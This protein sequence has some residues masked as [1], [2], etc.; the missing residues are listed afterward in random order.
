[1]SPSKLSPGRNA[2]AAEA[3][4]IIWPDKVDLLGVEVSRV[5]YREAV[6]VIVRAAESGESGIVGCHAVHAIVTMAGDEELREMANRY[7]MITPDGQPVRWAMNLL[8]RTGLKDRVYGPELMLRL[9][10]QCERKQIPIYLYGGNE[11]VSAKLVDSLQKQF[12]GLPI[13]GA[14]APPFRPLTEQE[15]REVVNRIRHSGAKLVFVGLGCPK[16]DLFAH[17]HRLSISAVQV[18]VGAAF[19][20]HA[21]FKPMA[22]DWM[23][24][25]GLE[26][27]YRFCQEPRRLWK[28]YLVTN[29]LFIWKV[30]IAWLNGKV[31]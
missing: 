22:P 28:R 8:H 19:D 31:G 27:L 10:A 6:D 15:D 1:M 18:C 2:P 30:G 7:K 4:P 14:E 16:Q 3:Q 26:W 23:Q 9:C 5:N 12:P 24:R 21:G 20:F 17:Q 25:S 13:A 29:S 11:E